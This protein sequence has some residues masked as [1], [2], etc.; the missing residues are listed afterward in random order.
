MR[1]T[2][3]EPAPPVVQV[4]VAVIVGSDGRILISRR[5]DDVHQGGLWEFPGGKLE[6]GENVQAALRRELREELGIE[7]QRAR[8]LICVHH[9]YSEQ[10]VLLDV[11]KVDAFAGTPHGREG[12][13]VLWV[14]RD[15]LPDFTFPAANAP[16]LRAARLPDRYLITPEPG[17]DIETFLQ[18]LES[19][20]ARGV[21]MLQL[22][23]KSLS[24]AA[25]RSLA[26]QVIAMAHR[27]GVPVL[28]NGHLELVDGLGADGA[29]LSAL[30]VQ[31]HGTRPLP[32][33]R[34]LGA[35]CHNVAELARAQAIG[36]DFA[37]LSPVQSTTSH[38]DAPVLG[39]DGFHA[40]SDTCAMPLYA[41]GGM[42]EA[43]LERAWSRGAQ[44][45]AAIRGLWER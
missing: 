29:H 16:I 10:S 1:T 23:A 41:L 6:P 12:Q 38:P 22:R 42:A 20:L 14:E 32:A 44:G 17:D 37:V 27:R 39:W 45:I 5:P 7:V 21:G 34:W 43:D 25:Y 28:L 35:S 9:D 36:A 19:V 4:A 2:V 11:W 33:N 18:Q 31:Q 15:H 13:P 30:Q 26:E 3:P 40:L 24:D 8:P